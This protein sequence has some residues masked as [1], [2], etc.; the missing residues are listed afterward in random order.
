MHQGRSRT[1]GG[2]QLLHGVQA[3]VDGGRVAQRVRGPGA[4]PA[5]AEGRARAVEQPQQRPV[6]AALAVVQYLQLP[7]SAQVSGFTDLG[8]TRIPG[9]SVLASQPGPLLWSTGRCSP[10]TCAQQQSISKHLAASLTTKRKQALLCWWAA[11]PMYRFSSLVH[12]QSRQVDHARAHMSTLGESAISAC[13]LKGAKEAASRRMAS[14]PYC[15][16]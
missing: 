9:L 13:V 6:L 12:L 3:L 14:M 5:R 15:L 2:S 1:Q 8:L 4:Q 7:A 11:G 10:A 16:R